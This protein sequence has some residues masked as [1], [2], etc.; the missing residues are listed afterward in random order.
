[1]CYYVQGKNYIYPTR[2][3]MIK[4][5]P[6]ARGRFPTYKAFASV[7]FEEAFTSDELKEATIVKSECMESS[8]FENKGNGVFERKALPLLC[9]TSPIFGMLTGDYTSDGNLDIVITGNS[10]STEVSTGAYDA[11]NGI[12]LVGDGKGNFAVQNSMQTGLR[13][14]GDMK[15][16]ASLKN[17]DGSLLLLASANSGQL[18]SFRCAIPGQ[19][20]YEAG[21]TSMYAIITLKNGKKMK[22]EFYWGNAYLSS[23][24]RLIWYDKQNTTM[25]E[26]Y[27]AHGNRTKIIKK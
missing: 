16:I 10:N 25:I 17:A 2:D 21:N 5:M 3:E 4:Q 11:M 9:Q 22:Q 19:E 15:G 27:D 8:Y 18:Q 26:F 7:T 1:M 6:A 20:S 12:L 14:P 23:S 24:D 13:T